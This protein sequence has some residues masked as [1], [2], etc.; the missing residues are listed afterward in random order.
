MVTEKGETTM[1]ETTN[2][3]VNDS[4]SGPWIREN[5]GMPERRITVPCPVCGR[6]G[7]VPVAG[8]MGEEA[9][10]FVEACLTCKGS[11]WVEV[12]EGQVHMSLYLKDPFAVRR[13]RKVKGE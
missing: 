9:F 10:K 1:V 6:R 8:S 4:A 5:V 7:K 2:V 3:T 11:G 12:G 13:S